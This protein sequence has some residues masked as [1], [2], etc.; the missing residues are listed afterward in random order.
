MERVVFVYKE[1]F[2]LYSPHFGDMR[3]GTFLCLS[4]YTKSSYSYME[5][6][7]ISTTQEVGDTRI[8][9]VQKETLFVHKTSCVVEMETSETC[10]LALYSPHFGDMRTGAFLCLY[11]YTKSSYTYMERV[12]FVYKELIQREAVLFVYSRHFGKECRR[13]SIYRE[14]CSATFS[15]FSIYREYIENFRNAG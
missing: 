10:A 3:T 5:R 11:S 9:T 2:F 12:A 7:A 4:S 8:G 6:V 13:H 15:T 14:C 1:R